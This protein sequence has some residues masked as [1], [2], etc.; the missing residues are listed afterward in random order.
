MLLWQIWFWTEGRQKQ[1]SLPFS[2]CLK[3]GHKF[4]RVPPSLC[5]KKRKVHHWGSCRSYQLGA[6]PE[7]LTWQTFS[8]QSTISLQSAIPGS[9]TLLSFVLSFLYI[10]VLC[11][12]SHRS[13]SSKSPLWV[14]HFSLGI[15]C[16]Y[17]KYTRLSACFSS[18]TQL[19]DKSS[20]PK[21]A[22]RWSS[23]PELGIWTIMISWVHIPMWLWIST[24]TTTFMT[25][26][27]HPKLLTDSKTK[28]YLANDVAQGLLPFL[29]KKFTYQKG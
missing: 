11:S 16:V 15:S 20:L 26:L 27:R 8:S 14:I 5:T 3:V 10:F 19:L 18:V 13:W 6:I 28:T 22:L 17:M 23:Q 21:E 2:I 29:W 12:R 24:T 9:L 4:P 25:V 7:K 1:S